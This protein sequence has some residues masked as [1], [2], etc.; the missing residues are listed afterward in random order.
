MNFSAIFTSK[1]SSVFFLMTCVSACSESGSV[2]R[3]AAPIPD[4]SAF[5]RS[6][7]S[8]PGV[9]RDAIKAL[10]ETRAALA[11]CRR[12]KGAAVAQY[13]DVKTRFGPQ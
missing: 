3:V 9:D 10:A 6:E 1:A 7:C 11:E 13:D 12:K 8:D 2:P 4:L 5:A